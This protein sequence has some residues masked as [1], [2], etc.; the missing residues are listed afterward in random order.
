MCGKSVIGAVLMMTTA[1]APAD[2]QRTVEVRTSDVATFYRIYD[3]ANGKPSA[4]LLQR[5]YIDEGTD[6]VRQFVP[7]RIISGE[8]LAKEV[9]NN[10]STYR[11]ARSCMEALPAVK[12][13]LQG[14]FQRLADLDPQATFPPVTILV[15]RNNSGGTTGKS[16]VLIGLEVAC[17]SSWLQPDLADRLYHLIAHEY[18]HVEQSVAL[19]EDS[20]NTTV[21]KQSLIEGVAELVAELISG[22]V[23]NIHLQTWTEGH[24]NDIGQRFLAEADN[25]D[26]SDWLY[27]GVGTP[28]KPGDLGY[29]VGYRIAK[30]YYDKATDKRVALRNLLD[31]EDPK[32]I[33]GD[34][35]W[36][37]GS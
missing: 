21:L 22:Q 13:K 18:G 2:I 7:Y 14:A 16:G 29:W 17:R 34:S 23:S 5:E 26:I 19:E 33:L 10:G 12:V 32:A 11:Q 6:G 24:S 30:A 15:G 27:S 3:A 1:A 8:A 4:D 20:D 37:P 35:G 25:T 36:Q 28:E 31:L 9:G